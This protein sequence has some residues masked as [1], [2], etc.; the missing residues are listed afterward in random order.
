I[1]HLECPS[2]KRHLNG[3][4]PG[5]AVYSEYLGR[6]KSREQ[7][8][9]FAVIRPEQFAEHAEIT[10]NIRAW[11]EYL[12]EGRLPGYL[13]PEVWRVFQEDVIGQ[14]NQFVVADTFYGT[15][16]VEEVETGWVDL[17][18]A[19][20]TFKIV[21]GVCLMLGAWFVVKPYRIAAAKEGKAA[22][23][24]STNRH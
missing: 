1:K 6:I 18:G 7:E 21:A 11:N 10:G 3:G 9:P 12:G 5:M 19:S 2:N 13:S 24:P 20:I 4:G 14:R 8:Y 23:W 22:N 15:E 16:E 17:P